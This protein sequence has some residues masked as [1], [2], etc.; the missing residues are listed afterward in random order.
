MQ[1]SR[2]KIINNTN[3]D[4]SC[5]AIHVLILESCFSGQSLLKIVIA[6]QQSFIHKKVNTGHVLYLPIILGEG[7]G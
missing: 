2:A 7:G 3:L 4:L 5:F 6:L 1:E